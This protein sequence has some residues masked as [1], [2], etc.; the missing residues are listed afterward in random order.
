MGGREACK[1]Q[2]DV[3]G[4]GRGALGPFEQ[5]NPARPAVVLVTPSVTSQEA[6]IPR[7]QDWNY[8]D[9]VQL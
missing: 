9:W 7:S 5:Q 6:E 4:S 3:T 8:Q 1:R 2:P